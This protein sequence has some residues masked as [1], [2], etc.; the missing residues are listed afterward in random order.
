[1]TFNV[2]FVV[3]IDIFTM[4]STLT[5]GRSSRPNSPNIEIIDLTNET[6]EETSLQNINNISAY[7]PISNRSR[8]TSRYN[9][10]FVIKKGIHF[11]FN[12]FV[13]IFFV[14]TSY[15]LIFFTAIYIYIY[16][17]MICVYY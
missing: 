7:V 17:Y 4:A 12:C 9:F 1:M 8:S 3:E 5:N 16:I 6:H 13:N 2:N 14:P 10:N 15:L 11:N